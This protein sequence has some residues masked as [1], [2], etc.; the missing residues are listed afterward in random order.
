[1]QSVFGYPNDEAY[2]HDPRGAAGDTHNRG[3]HGAK[4][5]STPPPRPAGRIPACRRC[6]LPGRA[7]CPAGAAH[8]AQAAAD[9]V[10]AA[11]LLRA[12]M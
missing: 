4:C 5:G 3:S 7:R 10:G 8:D 9:A 2:W 11:Q 6:D 1:M 12:I